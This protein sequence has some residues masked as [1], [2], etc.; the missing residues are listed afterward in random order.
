MSINIFHRRNVFCI[1]D[2]R[3]H[4]TYSHVISLH[5]YSYI[6]D[7]HVQ[8]QHCS[9]LIELVQL[10][11]SRMASHT[12]VRISFVHQFISA[13]LQSIIIIISANCEC[14][15]NKINFILDNFFIRI[16]PM[17]YLF[18][19]WRLS[20]FYFF[21]LSS[22]IVCEIANIF[23]ILAS[24]KINKIGIQVGNI[25]AIYVIIIIK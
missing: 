18:F 19:N 15:L 11:E 8:W 25:Y 17:L 12:N 21:L 10:S 3:Q 23:F 16:Y 5:Q 24:N 9:S 20:I 7:I 2:D 13:S 1:D 4:F 6:S 14:R 22:W